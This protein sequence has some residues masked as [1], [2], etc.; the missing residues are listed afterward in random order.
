MARGANVA[1]LPV[2][3]PQK[4]QKRRSAYGKALRVPPPLG[5]A[6]RAPTLVDD[7]LGFHSRHHLDHLRVLR[8]LIHLLRLANT[9]SARAL[10]LLSR[11]SPPTW[12][13]P[14]SLPHPP[15]AKTYLPDYYTGAHSRR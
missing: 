4:V 14:P 10:I 13:L 5:S 7:D 11:P 2:R 6:L 3:P 1:I 9:H 8:V 12:E 15:V